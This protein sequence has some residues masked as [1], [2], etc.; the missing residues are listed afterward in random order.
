MIFSTLGWI[1][2]AVFLGNHAYLSFYTNYKPKLYFALNFLG[3]IALVVSSS[4]ISSWQAVATNFF[5]GMISLIA[6]ANISV[7]RRVSL[8]EVWIIT[9]IAICGV[10]GIAS[11]LKD[12]ATG[13]AILGWA[14]GVLFCGAYLLFTT[15]TIKRSRFL[16]YNIVAAM[17][18]MPILYL[19]GN[20]P[21]FGLEIA[22]IAV[23]LFGWTQVQINT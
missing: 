2:T 20:W 14:A 16:I 11:A 9:L 13:M 4:V 5:W 23:S 10:T 15:G 22:W 19:Q 8:S 21:V 12:Y 17:S 3:A 7:T 6:L 1:G 18:L